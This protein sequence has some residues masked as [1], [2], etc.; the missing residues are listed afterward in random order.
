MTGRSG[1]RKDALRHFL[2]ANGQHDGNPWIEANLARC[3][4]ELGDGRSADEYY[5]RAKFD[6]VRFGKE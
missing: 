1:R 4:Y 3:Y 2:K 6:N 5:K